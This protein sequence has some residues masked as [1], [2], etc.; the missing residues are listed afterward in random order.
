[1]KHFEGQFATLSGLDQEP[2]SLQQLRQTAFDRF[3]EIGFPQQSWEAWRFTN[4][5]RLEQSSFRL[6]TAKDLPSISEEIKESRIP[7]LL[8]V[9]GHYQPDQSPRPAGL[10][11]KT[12]LDSYNEDA[13]LVTNGYDADYSPFSVL[14]T[15][16][17]TSGLHLTFTNEFSSG[18]VVRFLYLTTKLSEPIMNHPRLVVDVADGGEVTIVE[19]YRGNGEHPY[20]NN[21]LTAF[22]TGQNS[23]LNHI[24]IQRE[25]ESASHLG[26]TFYHVPADGVVHGS[27]LS[28]GS[29]LHRHDLNVVL[30]GDGADVSVNGLCLTKGSQHADHNIIMDHAFEHVTSRMLFKY[31]LADKSSGVFNGRALVRQDAQKIDANQ[32]N[33]NLLLSGDALMNSNP[34]LEIYA[35]DVRCTHGSTTGQIND[36]ALFYLRS[37]GLDIAAAK[38]LLINGFANE[39]VGEI[40]DDAVQTYAKDIL[41]TWLEDVNH[42]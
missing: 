2:L 38:A 19:E 12:L 24:R 29:A 27:Y 30:S 25:A 10:T 17:M 31:I 23:K 9:N 8:F 18:S 41:E 21:T 36:D 16:M 26:A 28:A 14:N 5:K 4:V 37:R 15:A 1:M 35:D 34:Q 7:T 6:S 32:T 33:N 3:K 39:V 22:R 11:V 13:K 20:W 40:K 42:G